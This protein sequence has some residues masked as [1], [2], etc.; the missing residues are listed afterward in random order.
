MTLDEMRRRA[1]NLL[2]D[3]TS[4]PVFWS[5]DE[6]AQMLQ[7][8]Q[9]TYAEEVEALT[10][11]VYIPL[12]AGKNL[13]Q[14]SGLGI[15]CMTPLR[16]WSQQRSHRL[17]PISQSE[18][19]GHYDRWLTVQGEPEWWGL[20]SWDTLFI[21][22]APASGGGVLELDCAV[23]PEPLEDVSDVPL[24]PDPDHD[25]FV[26]HAV[27]QGRA[28]Q[29]QIEQALEMSKDWMAKAKDGQARSGLQTV[30][31]RFF[32]REGGR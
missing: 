25:A 23:W 13:Y 6:I 7:D 30:Q 8:A 16:L 18:L 20:H 32:V 28:K 19:T 26:R 17:W 31:E 27:M 2:D 29:W 15:A 11:T 3:D 1:L 14:L 9:E 5:L 21:W 10:Q 12:T 24:Y 22:P 4:A